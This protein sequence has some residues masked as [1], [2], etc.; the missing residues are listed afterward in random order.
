MR[1]S[2]LE[3]KSRFLVAREEIQPTS[4]WLQA[5]NQQQPAAGNVVLELIQRKATAI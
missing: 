3:N 2:S 4:R 1:V 5:T